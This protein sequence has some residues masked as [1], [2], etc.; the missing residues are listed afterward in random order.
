MKKRAEKNASAEKKTDLKKIYKWIFA[1][2]LAIIVAVFGFCF[3]VREGTNA[4]VSRFG[5]V[6][7]VYTD[8][9]LH[10]KLPYP[11]EKVISYD[12]RS[13]YMDSGYTETLTNDKKNILCR[14][15]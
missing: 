13:Q 1:V 3:T 7:G 14:R 6:R 8:A 11:F 5:N 4:I 12:T 9:G 15:K 2:L 10:F